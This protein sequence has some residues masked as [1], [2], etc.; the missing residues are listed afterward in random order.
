M[1]DI[2]VSGGVVGDFSEVCGPF[3]VTGVSGDVDTEFDMGNPRLGNYGCGLDD[4]HIWT[5]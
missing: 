4:I 1:S 2:F 3:V 5:V